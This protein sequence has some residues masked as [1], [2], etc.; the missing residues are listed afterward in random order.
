[1]RLMDG[2]NIYQI[3]NNC[4]TSVKVIEEFYAAHIKDRLDAA[5]INV[6][7]PKPKVCGA[8]VQ[9][10]QDALGSEPA[11]DNP[12]ASTSDSPTPLLDKS[13]PPAI[14]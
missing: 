8:R 14:T 12:S 6:R 4:R 13:T 10:S 3:A 9:N 11:S 7:R 2:A 5:A 1:M